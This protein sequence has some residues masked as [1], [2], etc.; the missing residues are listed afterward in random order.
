MKWNRWWV[1][2][3]ACAVAGWSC[4]ATAQTFYKWTDERGVVHFSDSPPPSTHNVEERHLARQPVI[5]PA[6]AEPVAGAESPGDETS[7]RKGKSGE[8]PSR[9]ILLSRQTPRTGPSALH[10]T[11]RVKNVGGAAAQRVSVAISAVDSTQGT[12]C[13]HEDSP[14]TP[15]TL[16]PGET[17]D[18][19]VSLDSPCLYGE[20]NLDVAPTWE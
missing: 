3:V 11:G 1:T 18:F 16:G 7:G 8:G 19:D 12:P 10:L 17:G 14:V 4:S 6:P 5:E 15:S 2:L 9:V 13:L 20:P